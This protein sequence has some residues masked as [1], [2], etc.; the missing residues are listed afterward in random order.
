M[1]IPKII[2]EQKNKPSALNVAHK[3]CINCGGEHRTLA[4]S[5][6]SRKEEVRK[7][8]RENDRKKK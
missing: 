6:P 2:V 8:N 4:N 5:C 1:V 3:R 7:N